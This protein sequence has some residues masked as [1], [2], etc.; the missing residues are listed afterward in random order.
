MLS[1]TFQAV[2]KWENGENLPDASILL[3]LADVLDTTTDQILNGGQLI[4]RRNRKVNIADLKVGVEA[5]ASLKSCFGEYSLFYK[6]A[7]EGINNRMNID[8]E[9]C[10][11]DPCGK[12]DVLAE[13]VIQSLM[14]GYSVDDADID[15]H[16]ASESV[17]RQI[18]KY[19]F[20]CSLFS[21]QASH[22]KKFRPSYPEEIVELILSQKEKPVIAD[23]GSGTGKLSELLVGLAQTLYAIEPNRQMRQSAEENMIGHS[24]Y[25]SIAAV[26]EQTTLPDDSVDIIAVAEAFHWF[27]NEKAHEEMRRILKTDGYVFLM[28]NVFGGD[29][30]DEELSKIKNAYCA[31]KKQKA[32]GISYK[33]RADHLFGENHYHTARFDNSI[34]QSFEEFCGGMLSASFAP[35]PN[36]D[37]YE[38]FIS[39]VNELFDKYEKAGKLNTSITTVC[40]WGKLED[41]TK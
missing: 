26:A 1:V 17:K 28:W 9:R 2:S 25:I 32:S 13:A 37:K 30:F 27:D 7:V 23:I 12:E 8:I 34:Q 19:R 3:E 10:L 11:M 15:E 5:L 22:Y 21:A 36:D 20:D 31:R 39:D 6:G 38:R 4:I 33:E 35:N 18:R 16:F 41:R 40:Y 24:N 14:N 29:P